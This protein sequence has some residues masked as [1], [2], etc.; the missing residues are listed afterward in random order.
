MFNKLKSQINKLSDSLERSNINE[1]IYILG[2]KKEIIIRNLLA[3]IFRGIGIAIGFTLLGALVI[4][5][6]QRIVKLNLPVIGKYLA[7]IVEVVEN[8][9]GAVKP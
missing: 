4:M 2:S 6:L 7:E 3:G 8:N 1:L 5:L 9:K